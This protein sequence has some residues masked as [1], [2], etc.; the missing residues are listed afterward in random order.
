MCGP[1]RTGEGGGRVL[2]YGPGAEADGLDIAKGRIREALA[3]P[4]SSGV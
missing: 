2:T 4:A 3:E 1:L